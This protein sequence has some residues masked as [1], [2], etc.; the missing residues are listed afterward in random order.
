MYVSMS[1]CISAERDLCCS[2]RN[3]RGPMDLGGSYLSPET[4]LSLHNQISELEKPGFQYVLMYSEDTVHVVCL[5]FLYGGQHFA[6]GSFWEKFLP[7]IFSRFL[8]QFQPM[9][10]CCPSVCLSIRLTS[11]FWLAF[12]YKF[13]NWQFCCMGFSSFLFCSSFEKALHYTTFIVIFIVPGCL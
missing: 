12:A 10:W 8:R 13:W 5:Y 7:K 4:S 6:E 3:S 9:D 11:T 2:L 1:V